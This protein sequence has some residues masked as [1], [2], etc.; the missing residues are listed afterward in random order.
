MNTEKQIEILRQLQV[1]QDKYTYFLL[2]AATSAVAFVATRTEGRILGWGMAPLGL[3][4]IGWAA[5]FLFG[6]RHLA[7][8]SATLYA[9]AGLLKVQSGED[10]RVGGHPEAIAMAADGIRSAAERNSDRA[11]E[12][13]LWQFRCFLGGCALF[14]VWRVIEML[15]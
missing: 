10:R 6:C 11:G 9:N 13:A 1:S 12:L 8:V 7:Y 4:V 3:A 2:A 5:S 14:L 15:P